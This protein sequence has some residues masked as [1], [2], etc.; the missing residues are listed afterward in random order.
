M[1]SRT[2][3]LKDRT[4]DMESLSIL[5]MV[6]KSLVLSHEC[7][8]IGLWGAKVSTHCTYDQH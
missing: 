3:G 2:A 4:P 1:A 8:N 6:G 7:G 5:D